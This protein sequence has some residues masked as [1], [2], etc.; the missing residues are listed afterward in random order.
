[1]LWYELGYIVSSWPAQD[2]T[3]KNL[4]GGERVQWAK[5]TLQK[6][7]SLSSNPRTHIKVEGES[8]SPLTF[9]Y[10]HIHTQDNY[11]KIFLFC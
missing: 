8:K 9:I 1:M 6:P 5:C 7:G 10:I 2:A 11:S 3:A 4:L